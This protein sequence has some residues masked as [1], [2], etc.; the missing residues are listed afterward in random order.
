[1]PNPVSSSRR[2]GLRQAVFEGGLVVSR[3][4]AVFGFMAIMA[5]DPI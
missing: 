4:A 5:I 3:L 1:L 2:I